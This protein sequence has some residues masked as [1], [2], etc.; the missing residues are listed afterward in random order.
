VGRGDLPAGVGQQ[1]HRLPRPRHAPAGQLDHHLPAGRHPVAVTEADPLAVAGGQL[2]IGGQRRDPNG[3]QHDTARLRPGLQPAHRPWA[4][5]A[6]TVTDHD[7]VEPVDHR[8]Q[9]VDPRRITG[10]HHQPFQGH[11]DV[12][13]GADAELGKPGDTDP[14]ASSRRSGGQRQRQRHP[15]RAVAGHRGAALECGEQLGQ[16]FVHGQG[17]FTGGGQRR[18]T[19]SQ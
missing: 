9:H 13:G 2:Q 10:D 8:C 12:G 18:K 15:G 4:E 19:F 11:A 3:E 1:H 7:D 5:A 6:G 17:S 14:G 16:R